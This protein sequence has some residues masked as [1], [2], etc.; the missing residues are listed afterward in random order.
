[1]V[2]VKFHYLITAIKMR[3][4]FTNKYAILHAIFMLLSALP[5]L[6][7]NN[8][9]FQKAL[10]TARANNPVLKTRF[11][12][13]GIAQ[14]DIVTAKLRPNPVLN[15][16]SLQLVK[17]YYFAANTPWYDGKNRQVWWQLTKSFQLPS[18]RKYKIEVADKNVAYSQ[19]VYT[20]TERGLLQDV[21][22]RWV[23]VWTAK[24]QLDILK[25]AK[26]NTDSLVSINKL[27]LKNQT[28]TQ[29]DLSRTELLA[30]QYA[31]QIKSAEQEYLNQLINLKFLLGVQDDVQ[32]DTSDNF[33]FTFNST[34]DS[35]MQ[36]ALANRPD[37]Q[38][39]KLSI[40]AASSNIKLQKALAYP[41]P[42]LGAIYNPQN[43]IPYLGFYATIQIPIFSRNQG[44]I[45]KSYLLK[46][47]SE[48][49]LITTQQQIKTEITSAYN[50]YQ[51]Q[52]INLQNFNGL[53]NQSTDILNAVKYSYLKGG[54]TIID[55]LEAQRSWLDTQQQYY[56]TLQIYRQSYIQL[57]YASGLINQLAQ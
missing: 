39:L 56:Q 33:A 51:T 18:Q 47:Q 53:L 23:D 26:N 30:S 54:T 46:Q 27:R 41:N 50:S 29:T 11:L 24:K 49:G 21:A 8:Y 43:T 31:I 45:K 10:Q 2:F 44:E 6:A 12:D 55:Y 22:G 28:I 14:T 57:L 20:E 25:A 13:I 35:L 48:Q 16:Q 3:F 32:I 38:T 36:Q 40:D 34:M 5:L 52:K 9:S 1:M 37:I 15:N 4:W 42:E 19:K 7:Q 17:P